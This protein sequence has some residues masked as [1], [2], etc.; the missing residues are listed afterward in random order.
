IGY[1]PA[2]D[3]HVLV[4]MVREKRRTLLLR[5]DPTRAAEAKP[6]G[7]EEVWKSD[8]YQVAWSHLPATQA[9]YRERVAEHEKRLD[10]VPPNTWTHLEAPYGGWGRAYGS[11]CH[12]WDRDQIVL[13]GGGHSAYMGNEVSQYDLKANLWMESWS[14]ELPPYPYG[15]PDGP[16][17]HP[18][19]YHEKGTH[20][21][22]HH[23][24]Y[25]SD[26]KRI[27]F[28]GGAL[29]YDPD[30]MRYVRDKLAKAGKGS[31]G[32]SV[33]MSGAPG[34]LTVSTRHWYGSPFGVWRADFK[35]KTLGRIPG[36]DTP[37][38]TND[39][40]KAVFDPTRR[41]VLFYGAAKEGKKRIC[42]QLWAF[43]LETKRW[44][45]IAT[46][47][48]PAGT[49]PPEIRAWNYCYSTTH[50]CLLIAAKDTWVY[51]CKANV[52]RKI[53]PGIDTSGVV[54]SA[55]HGLFYALC[56]GGYKPQQ[57]YVFRYAPG[58]R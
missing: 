20:H 23:Y 26:L 7:P 35:A 31:A 3:V 21:G 32:H 15:H 25:C 47:T 5:L 6:G 51:D 54:Y 41:R 12:D 33:E 4:D 34:L 9:E 37:F 27:V 55:K 50:D 56:G 28:F 44:E 16:G 10:A 8:K 49:E 29:Q 24:V 11:F 13:W 42:N 38:G 19:F 43:P 39:R 57:V 53:G 30:R 52:L 17:W 1:D 58:E 36:S 22:Y 2:N 46:K 14:P 18:S 40:A 45:H 48:E